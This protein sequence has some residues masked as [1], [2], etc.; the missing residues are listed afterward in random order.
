M[1]QDINMYILTSIKVFRASI[2]WKFYLILSIVCLFNCHVAYSFGW[3]GEL[4]NG[5]EISN[6]DLRKILQNHKIWLKSKGKLGTQADFSGAQI[7]HVNLKFA[8]LDNAIFSNAVLDG[9]DFSRA[10]LKYANFNNA[11]LIRAKFNNAIMYS[12]TF[13]NADLYHARLK[14]AKLKNGKMGWANLEKADLREAGLTNVDFHKCRLVQTN[15]TWAVMRN[16]NLS[17]SDLSG[18][19]ILS[20]RMNDADFSDANLENAIFEPL[21]LPLIDKIA[22]SR[23]LEFIKFRFTPDPIINLQKAFKEEGFDKQA[24]LLQKALDN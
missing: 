17:G 21:E 13:K 9:A 7:Q 20:V 18:A 3:K 4:K 24:V 16:S 6:G 12:A 23:G 11:S 2:V 10:N 1:K 22:N 19:V 5:K 15:M 8:E 14:R